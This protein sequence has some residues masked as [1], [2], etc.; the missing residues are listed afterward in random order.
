MTIEMTSTTE[1]LISNYLTA[2]QTS[3]TFFQIE[4]DNFLAPISTTK[5][6]LV[7]KI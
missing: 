4:I 2:D 7:A 3:A 5:I 6:S 1:L